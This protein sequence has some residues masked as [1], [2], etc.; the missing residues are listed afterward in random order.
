MFLTERMISHRG[1]YDNEKIFENS[2]EAIRK[3]VKKG[4]TVEIDIHLTK[5]NRLVVFHDYNTK[6]ITKEDL[7]IENHTY[8]EINNQKIIHIPLLEEVLK[9]VNGKVPLL[10]EIKQ[11]RK[12]GK[13]EQELVNT[14]KNYKGDYAIQSFNVKT[15]YWFKKHYPNILRG[16]LSSNHQK[17]K[18]FFVKKYF[19]KKMLFNFLTKPNF[20]SYNYKEL[21][22]KEIKKLKKKYIVLGWTIK[23]KTEYNKYIKY[24]DN[25][26]CEQFINNKL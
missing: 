1:I 17:A 7:V 2:I 16:Q 18:I 25:L 13:L 10:I 8:K 24:Y 21:T 20:I 4:Y 6:R 12:V 3:A 26:I 5:D 23:T 9:I 14:L 22:I 19:L 15:I 11:N